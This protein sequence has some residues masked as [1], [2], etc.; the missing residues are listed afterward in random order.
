M[1]VAYDVALIGG[2]IIGCGTFYQL[3]SQ[4]YRCVLLEKNKELMAAASAGNSGIVH[5]GFDALPG[6]IEA[7]CLTESR[8]VNKEIYKRLGIPYRKCGALLVAWNKEELEKLSQI[9]KRSHEN[10]VTNVQTLSQAQLRKQEP[11]LSP[12]ALGALWIADE[13][14]VDPNLI[15][16]MLA[17][18]GKISGSDIVQDCC[19]FSGYRE[20]DLTW[21][22]NTTKGLFKAKMII[23]SAGLYGNV[24][25]EI[26]APSKFNIKPR[27]GQFVIFDSTAGLLLNSMIL[28]IPSPDT[29]GIIVFPTVYNNVVVGPTNEDVHFKETPLCT[30]VQV[31]DKL[32]S[33]AYSVIPKLRHY[34]AEATYCGLRP[35][36][37]FK[38]YQINCDLRRKWL[39]LGGIRSTGLSAWPGIARMAQDY[40]KSVLPRQCERT[41]DEQKVDDS[42]KPFYA[43]RSDK[44]VVLGNSEYVVTHPI[45]RCV[46]TNSKL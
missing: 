29:K 20:S 11:N 34:Q 3:S 5:T 27:M 43:H 22:L 17:H 31:I 21:A 1:A 44:R 23:N 13:A 46:F 15:G 9:R 39:T 42:K 40:V 7:R 24:V 25:E 41:G 8:S 32:K 37:E 30:D 26:H 16:V 38:D 36:T 19:V 10:G 33:H 45:S 14:V 4:G 18:H 2:G 6:T 28:P 35:A 12:A